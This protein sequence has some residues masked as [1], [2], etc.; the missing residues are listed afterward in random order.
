MRK[1]SRKAKDF[2]WINQARAQSANLNRILFTLAERKQAL[3]RKH[4]AYP[5]LVDAALC[6]WRSAFLVYEERTW[7]KGMRQAEEVLY[8]LVAHNRA[9]YEQEKTNPHW[10]FGF[11]MNTAEECVET[12]FTR[13]SSALKGKHATKLRSH[14]S[15]SA[16]MK[17]RENDSRS[18]PDPKPRWKM[19]MDA[20]TCLLDCLMDEL[21]KKRGRNR[22]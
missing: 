2:L 22:S 12:A 17:R 10:F 1:D 11:Y 9:G 15:V 5:K 20:T 14:K 6:L 3:L 21:K 18:V 13:L 7:K 8:Q 19:A 4:D 16:I